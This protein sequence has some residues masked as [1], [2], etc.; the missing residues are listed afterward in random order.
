MKKSVCLA[1]IGPLV[2]TVSIF[3]TGCA[4]FGLFGSTDAVDD[5]ASEPAI[6]EDPVL[7]KLSFSVLH[8]ADYNLDDSQTMKG[9]EV[10]ETEA[11]Y[12]TVL[13][14]YSV[15]VPKQIDFTRQRVVLS[16]MGT[17][18]SGGYVVTV[19]SAHEY[20]GR[21]VVSVQLTSPGD[22]CVTT[23]ALSNP[24]EFVVIDTVKPIEFEETSVTTECAPL[25]PDTLETQRSP[26]LEED[27]QTA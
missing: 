3:V 6:V 12:R 27:R 1:C 5:A 22:Y 2:I 15:E 14:R 7:Q 13:A 4:S 24:Y 19:M 23:S 11:D 20:T 18:R 10:I 26:V 16:T 25:L 9:F 21:V 8:K 17:Q